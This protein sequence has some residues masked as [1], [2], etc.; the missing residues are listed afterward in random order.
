M[1]HLERGIRGTWRE[2]HGIGELRAMAGYQHA[3]PRHRSQIRLEGRLCKASHHH[4]RD[5]MVTA[6]SPQSSADLRST[7][8]ARTVRHCLYLQEH[9]G[10]Q[11]LRNV[12]VVWTQQCQEEFSMLYFAASVQVFSVLV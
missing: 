9:P 2:E 10:G 4:Y 6:G 11:I 8:Y 3:R 5:H 7:F 12:Y 1:W